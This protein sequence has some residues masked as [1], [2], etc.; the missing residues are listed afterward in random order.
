MKNTKIL[1]D[2]VSNK[3]W[4]RPT[5]LT[6]G[7]LAQSM[8]GINAAY[9]ATPASSSSDVELDETVLQGTNQEA[10]LKLSSSRFTAPLLD[11]PQTVNVITSQVIEQQAATSLQDVLRNSPGI[12]FRAGEG[13]P[14][15]GDNLFIRGFSATN[16]I[17]VDGVRSIGEQSR[18]AYNLE[19]VEV[20]KG[21]SSSN[22]GRG[23]AGGAINLVTKAPKLENASTLNASIGTDSFK[24]GTFDTNQI[25][26][27]DKGVAVRVVGM[28][29]ENDVPGRDFVD[30]SSWAVNPTLSYGLGTETTVTLGYEHFEEDSMPDYGLP[31]DGFNLGVDRSNFY[32]FTDRDTSEI[33]SDKVK[34]DIE[35][36]FEEDLVL[37]NT[38]AFNRTDTYIFVTKHNTVD[39]VAGTVTVDD[40]QRDR[41]VDNLTNQTTLNGVFETGEIK[42]KYALGLDLAKEN[43]TAYNLTSATYTPGGTGAT[44]DLYD[45]QNSGVTSTGGG[46]RTGDYTE[47]KTETVAAFF[48][49]T[50]AL[51]DQW[52]LN[53]NARIENYK[54]EQKDTDTPANDGLSDDDTLFSWRAGIVFKPVEAGSIYFAMGKSLTPPSS[55]SSNG[56]SLS[57]R[58]VADPLETE[59]Y[60]LG[61]KWGF[62]DGNL[63]LSA[64]LFHTELTNNQTTDPVTLQVVQVGKQISQGLEVG[65]S[66]QITD[67]WFVF[68]GFTILDS[69]VEDLSTNDGNDLYVPEMTLNFWSTYDL[70]DKLTVG[71]GVTYSGEQTYSE[72]GTEAPDD[73]AY[74]LVN[75]LVSYQVNENL[76]LQLNVDNLFDDDYIQRGS[77]RRT[78]P[79]ATR[80][81][82][83]SANYSF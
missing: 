64:A 9:A 77:T 4:I 66:G 10:P 8:L 59:S 57:T 47:V 17:F 43:Y 33:S 35:H 41:V 31:T 74:V 71:L 53:G 50:I 1:P 73:A 5:A 51:N 70:T 83:L 15:S 39:P 62:F 36:E 82:K 16:D 28:A 65:V 68:S 67:K 21:P 52:E 18:D 11:T 38:T 60:E 58:S 20:V 23:A 78:V 54:V 56:F 76:S 19:Q 75:G 81:A 24:R 27:E 46:E 44:L 29:T 25:L 30:R 49:D 80:F 61:T 34:F 55:T 3:T 22:F 14:P 2:T 69:E 26:S 63:S 40:R 79:G 7:T 48:G 37:R 32:G 45:P 6:A 12:T 13:G 42:H 72:D